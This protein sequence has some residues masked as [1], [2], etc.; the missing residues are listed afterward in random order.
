MTS[1]KASVA[2]DLVSRMMFMTRPDGTP[3]LK[4]IKLRMVCDHCQ[5]TKDRDDLVECVHCLG[6]LPDFQE[7]RRQS[8]LK[9]IM[10]GLEDEFLTEIRG[11]STNSLITPAFSPELIADLSSKDKIYKGAHDFSHL[12][13]AIDPSGGSKKSKYAC[14]VVGGTR[15][16]ELVVSYLKK[17]T[18]QK[19]NRIQSIH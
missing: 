14:V 11:L 19:K 16:D 1:E 8:D 7:D 9:A 12:F 15:S 13:M 17:F 2:D 4:V 18:A 10:K 6:F 5:A 3:L